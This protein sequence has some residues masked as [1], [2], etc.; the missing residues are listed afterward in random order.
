LDLVTTAA[1][2]PEV[3]RIISLKLSEGFPRR[4]QSIGRDIAR[5]AP[6]GQTSVDLAE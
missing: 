3:R 1:H 4:T 6:M 2:F 5:F